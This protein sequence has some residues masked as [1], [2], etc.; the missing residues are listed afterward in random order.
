MD[1]IKKPNISPNQR[2]QTA[3]QATMIIVIAIALI[4][5]IVLMG[6]T[7]LREQ[8]A[9]TREALRVDIVRVKNAGL[10]D[11]I[12]Q[13]NTAKKEL[14]DIYGDDLTES[15]LMYYCSILRRSDGFIFGKTL[16]YHHEC[17]WDFRYTI[18]YADDGRN[19]KRDSDGFYMDYDDIE[20]MSLSQYDDLYGLDENSDRYRIIERQK[21]RDAES[22]LVVWGTK[23]SHERYLPCRSDSFCFSPVGDK[24]VLP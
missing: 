8:T 19:W 17:F 14:I 20:S 16:G 11:A 3:R 21:T 22:P 23:T 5:A 6:Y 12:N 9:K 15:V 4:A 24:P 7:V 13:F 10:A 18:D 2:K 1:N